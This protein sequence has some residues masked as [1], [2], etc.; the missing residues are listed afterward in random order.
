LGFEGT[1]AGVGRAV[2]LGVTAV[3]VAEHGQLAAF[4]DKG[5]IETACWRRFDRGYRGVPGKKEE[6]GDPEQDDAEKPQ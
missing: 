3:A 5:S 6:T 4:G 2:L 1:A